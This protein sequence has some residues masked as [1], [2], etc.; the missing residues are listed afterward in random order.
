MGAVR[1]RTVPPARGVA[2]A[3]VYGLLTAFFVGGALTLLAIGAFRA[4]TIWIPEDVWASYLIVGGMLVVGGAFVW[5]RRNAEPKEE[6]AR[7]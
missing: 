5:A 4:L 6:T 7:R 2:K 3:I 1:D